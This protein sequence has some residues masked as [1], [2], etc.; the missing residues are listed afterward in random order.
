MLLNLLR[1]WC[2]W[3][4]KTHSDF[5]EY[6]K[7]LILISTF[8]V[9]ILFSRDSAVIIIFSENSI[10]VFRRDLF[11]YTLYLCI[12]NTFY[13]MC[14]SGCI[15]FSWKKTISCN[16]FSCPEGHGVYIPILLMKKKWCT[17]LRWIIRGNIVSKTLHNLYQ[18]IF[19]RYSSFIK[20]LKKKKIKKKYTWRREKQEK[21]V[22]VWLEWPT[23]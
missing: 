14:Y 4:E 13:W 9:G 23:Y 17:T 18:S 15:I 11:V 12:H 7:Y 21:F 5:Y 22:S 1:V 10:P 6:F 20:A 8:V 16:F 2:Y 3:N 19:L